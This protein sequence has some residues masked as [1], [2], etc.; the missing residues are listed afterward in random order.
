[1]NIFAKGAA[2]LVV[3]ASRIVVAAL[4]TI[5]PVAGDG[6][7]A[8]AIVEVAGGGVDHPG[9][10]PAVLA[11]EMPVAPGRTNRA[12]RNAR[13]APRRRASGSRRGR[14]QP[15]RDPRTERN[16]SG[17][18]CGHPAGARCCGS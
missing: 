15:S 14:S 18:G 11:C 9:L 13:L 12:G 4:T 1:V 7:R 2:R 5:P 8:A 16:G 10:V 3:N 17:R 6:V